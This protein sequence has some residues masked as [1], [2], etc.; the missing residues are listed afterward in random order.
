MSPDITSENDGEVEQ[1]CSQ[2]CPMGAAEDD[3]TPRAATAARSRTTATALDREAMRMH[4]APT[5]P[6]RSSCDDGCATTV[7]IPIGGN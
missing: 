3:E 6:T 1:T 5:L 7:R 2:E 4:T